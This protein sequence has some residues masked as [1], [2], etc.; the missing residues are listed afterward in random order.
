MY[1]DWNVRRAHMFGLLAAFTGLVIRLLLSV[2]FYGTP[3]VGFWLASS[4]AAYLGAPNWVAWLAGAFLFP[5]IPGAWEFHAWSHRRPEGK[6]W[7]TPLDRLSLRTFVV[8]LVF[9]AALL[10]LYPQTA[11]VSLST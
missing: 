4:L 9:L 2:V 6:A 5:I 1:N 3:L 8:G 10:C 11:F 7:L